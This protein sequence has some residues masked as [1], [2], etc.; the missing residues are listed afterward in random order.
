MKYKKSAGAAVSDEK[1]KTRPYR[2]LSKKEQET[3][4]YLPRHL[5]PRDRERAERRAQERAAVSHHKPS[6]EERKQSPYRDLSSE[7]QKNI[8]YLPDYLPAAA[9][10]R[11]ERQAPERAAA[12]HHKLSSEEREAVPYAPQQE[13][14][15]PLPYHR[16]SGEEQKSILYLPDYLPPRDRERAESR[17]SGSP[18]P[19]LPGPREEDR[20]IIGPFLKTAAAAKAPAVAAC[21][22]AAFVGLTAAVVKGV[23]TS[24]RGLATIK[25]EKELTEN[26]FRFPA[27]EEEKQRILKKELDKIDNDIPAP[28]SYILNK[29]NERKI[30]RE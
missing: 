24:S 29:L 23:D 7:E 5:P 10:E 9:R 28:P 25:I 1:R 17:L 16:L 2:K 22:M 19:A 12:P 8:L 18:P 11:A 21:F 14:A 20:P 30:K 26:G 6:S 15:K 3:I 4:P 13:A 27:K